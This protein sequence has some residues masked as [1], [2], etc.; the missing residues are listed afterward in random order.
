MVMFTLSRTFPLAVSLLLLGACN[1]G[2]K[3]DASDSAYDSAGDRADAWRS[4]S[5]SR[6]LS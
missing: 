1:W 3:D 5:R 2:G 4:C 6:R